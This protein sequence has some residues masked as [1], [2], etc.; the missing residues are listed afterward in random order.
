MLARGSGS[1][2]AWDT[3]RAGVV[4]KRVAYPDAARQRAR[5]QPFTGR[6]IPVCAPDVR[7]LVYCEG[8]AGT[9]FTNVANVVIVP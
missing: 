3:R 2:A 1:S 4:R 7:V 6:E 9:S 5:R 8:V